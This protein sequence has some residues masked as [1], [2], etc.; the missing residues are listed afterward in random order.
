MIKASAILEVVKKPVVL[1]GALGLVVIVVVWFVAFFQPESHKLS[2]LGSQKASLQQT[3]LLDNARLQRV[4]AESHHVGEIQAIDAKL[5][6]YVPTTEDLYTYIQTLSG[7]GN[8]AGIT[9]TSLQPSTVT[10]A[11]GTSYMAIPIT[12]DV[13]GTYDHLLAFLNA[14][15]NLPRLT[16][17]NGLTITGGGPGTNRSTS[18]SATFDLVIFTSQKAST[19]S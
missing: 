10:T 6:G 19:S 8:T 11:S 7:A 9:I 15:Y 14:I 17:V 4:R 1:L 12:A 3:V 2:S 13:K 16:D 18:L 5:K